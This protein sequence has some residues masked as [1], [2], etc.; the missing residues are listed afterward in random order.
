MKIF[1]VSK[2]WLKTGALKMEDHKMQTAGRN[3]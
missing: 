3:N 2:P 1:T